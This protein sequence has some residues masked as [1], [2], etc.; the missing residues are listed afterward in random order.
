MMSVYYTTQSPTA[1]SNRRAPLCRLNSSRGF[2]HEKPKTVIGNQVAPIHPECEDFRDHRSPFHLR[3]HQWPPQRP[4]RPRSQAGRRRSS[5][6]GS[7]I[8]LSLGQPPNNQ[9]SRHPGRPRNR[10][11]DQIRR[12]NNLPTSGGVLSIAV[13]AERR[14]GPCRCRLC[15]NNKV[16]SRSR[17]AQYR[18]ERFSAGAAAGGAETCGAVLSSAGSWAPQQQQLWTITCDTFFVLCLWFLT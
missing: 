6:Q 15:V 3:D 13:T 9:W 12:D 17:A 10:W 1:T 4:L 8:D 11:V 18:A 5:P 16:W 14:Y 7:Q 2:P